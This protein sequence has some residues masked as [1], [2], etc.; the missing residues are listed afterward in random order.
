MSSIAN[1]MRGRAIGFWLGA[2]LVLG[3]VGSGAMASQWF[4]QGSGT[5]IQILGSGARLSV[6]ITHDQ[7]RVLIASGSDGAAL[8]NSVSNALPPIFD[9]I[10]V[11]LIDPESSPGIVERIR[12]L[13]PKQ[14][15]TL[16]A[17]GKPVTAQTIEQSFAIDLGTFDP[18]IVDVGNST[19][20][21]SITT[22]AGSVIVGSGVAL[23]GRG[24][25]EV[26]IDGTLPDEFAGRSAIVI[27]PSDRS[28][29]IAGNRATVDPGAVMTIS[30]DGPYVRLDRDFFANP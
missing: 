12:D 13:S 2:G 16:P 14:I 23:S 25:I 21:V 26:D 15:F 6:L 27:Q 5:T 3:L 22:A 4:D 17:K 10:D 11:V 20:T 18:L 28:S 19:W 9:A 24:V 7:R 30:L 1:F 29:V 8:A